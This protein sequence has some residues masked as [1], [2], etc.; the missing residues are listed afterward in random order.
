[1]NVTLNGAPHDLADG[2]S[3]ATAVSLLT[4]SAAGVA[5]AVNGAVVRR[6]D[7]ESTG[8]ASGDRV[9]VITAVQGG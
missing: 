1:M 4:T 6:I 2:T 3:L 7:W 8:L 5:A 9:E